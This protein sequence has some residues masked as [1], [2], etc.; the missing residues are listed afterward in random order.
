MDKFREWF[1]G[2]W[3]TEGELDDK[4]LMRLH[5]E[6]N[7]AHKTLFYVLKGAACGRATAL[8]IEAFT[9]GAVPFGEL[10]AR[11]LTDRDIIEAG[12]RERAAKASALDSTPKPDAA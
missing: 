8:A 1:D 2:Q 7:I 5:L 3:K 10:V 11:R 9:N 4:A 6:T 12:K